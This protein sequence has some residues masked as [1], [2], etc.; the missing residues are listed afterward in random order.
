MKRD[1]LLYLVLFSLALNV[2]TIG[3][4]AYLRW[5]DGKV[6][7]PAT[8]GERLPFR[9][10]LAQLKLDDQ[11]RQALGRM[12]SGHWRQVRNFRQE[13]ARCRQELFTLMKQDPLPEWPLVEAK[14]REI[15]NLQLR[16]EEEMVR[17]LL[18]MQ[19]HLR[20]EQR[21]MLLAHLERQLGSIWGG[22]GPHHGRRFPGWGPGPPTHL[23]PTSQ[24]PEGK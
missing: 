7:A 8:T 16:M 11:Q 2:G 14:V 18:E 17:H 9:E 23:P 15:S 22:R 4:L 13:L 12:A 10:L 3:T 20:P 21:Q 5:Q 19:R 24:T 1:W 6:A